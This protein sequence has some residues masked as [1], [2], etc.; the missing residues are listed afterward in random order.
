MNTLLVEDL[1]KDD[2]EHRSDQIVLAAPLAGSRFG[3]LVAQ[4]VETPIQGKGDLDRELLGGTC[5]KRIPRSM[6][7]RYQN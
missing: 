6:T 2:L 4:L 5:W 7:T 3:H 1:G